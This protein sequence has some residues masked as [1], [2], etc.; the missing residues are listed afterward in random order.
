MNALPD[1]SDVHWVGV[2]VSK[3]SFDA[4]LSECWQHFPQIHPNELPVQKF[5]RS[6]KGVE[7]FL[8]WLDKHN[9]HQATVRV[10]MEATGKYSVELTLWMLES[11][12]TLAPAIVNPRFTAHF[13]KSMG[14][15]NKTDRMDACA[16]AFYGIERQ[17][18]AYTPPPPEYTELRELSRY[19]DGLVRQRTMLKNQTHE[20]TSSAV[21]RRNLAKRLG[22]LTKDIVRIESEM[23]TL[24]CKH[25]SLKH[26]VDLL[27]SI[28]G[29][30]FI[31]A[32]TIVA[33]LGD[34]RRFQ[35]ARQLTAFAGLSPQHR[36]SGTSVQGKSRIC[37][38]GNPRV[39]RCLYLAALS[40]IRSDTPFRTTYQ[41]LLQS[42]KKPRVALVA[43]MRKL[44][45]TMRA[46]LISG[47]P[48][49]RNHIG[50]QYA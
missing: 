13:I 39:R 14:L 38:Q 15:R 33:E 43:I 44:L 41:R 27:S 24:V 23:N 25:E 45:V 10:I 2:D 48:F 6:P 1:R 36:Q 5:E 32:T 28:C 35:L 12:P 8:R 20:N 34:L 22:L 42:G 49:N 3:D 30:A 16:L 11:C 29:T 19:R 46:I 4:A 21:V 37:K 40:A 50:Q 9:P 47:K 31:V 7:I 17:P 18:C 26:D